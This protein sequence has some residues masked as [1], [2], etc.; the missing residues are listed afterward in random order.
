MTHI[1]QVHWELTM[2][3]IGHPYYVSGNAIMHALGQHL[4]YDRH[5]HLHASHGIF[6]PGQ[7]GTFP[8]EHSQSGFRPYL[9]SGL[10]EVE[11]YDDL[12]LLR[13]ASHS[14]LLESRPRDALNTHDI[15]V[16]S[17]HPALSHETIMG[18]PEDA[19]RQ[20]QTTKWYLNAYLHADHEGV[21]PIEESTLE[22]LRFGGKRNYGYGSTRLKDTQVIDVEALEYSRLENGE[23]FIL[24]LITPFVL[25]SEYPDAHDQDIPWWWNEERHNLRERA[26]KILEQREVYNLQT[27]DHGQVVAYDGDRPVETAKRGIRRV[28]THSKYGF[29][30]LRVKPV[31]A[32]PNQ[33]QDSERK[34]K[35]TG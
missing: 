28:G 27:V 2:D 5:R 18:K 30:E 11:A 17:G 25:E 32:Q 20:L 14:W 23:A 8:D 16:Q 10:P 13:Q 1:Q 29:G 22:G 4:S 31:E 19:R 24:E 12:F 7:F 6:V 33:H 21:L 15:R 3:Y 26:E 9:G 35:A 34:R